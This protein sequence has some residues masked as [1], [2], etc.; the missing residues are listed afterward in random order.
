M[1]YP[2]KALQGSLRR[3]PL[4]PAPQGGQLTRATLFNNG[5]DAPPADGGKGTSALRPLSRPATRQ[6]LP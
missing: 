4:V 5:I 3:A 1:K 6:P 2:I